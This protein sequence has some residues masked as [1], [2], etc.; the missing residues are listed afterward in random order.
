[1]NKTWESICSKAVASP[2]K[3]A[4]IH[5]DGQ[6]RTAYTWAGLQTAV[7][8][9]AA[10]LRRDELEIAALYASNSPAW[11]VTDIACE[12]AGVTL[13]PL[14]GFFST[15]QLQHALNE[16]QVDAL[17]TDQPDRL[18]QLIGQPVKAQQSIHCLTYLIVDVATSDR[19]FRSQKV[20]PPNTQKVTF[21][22]GSTGVPKGVCLSSTHL[23]QVADSIMAATDS[24]RIDTHLC[25]LPLAILLE[26][27]AGIYAPLAR[28]AQVIVATEAALGFNGA[29]G[30]NLS[31]FLA[32]LQDCQPNSLIVFPQL[33]EALVCCSEAGW[34]LPPTLRFVAVG[35]ATVGAELLNRAWQQGLPVYEGYGLSECGSVVSLNTPA[36]RKNG[37]LGKPL[38]HLHVEIIDGEI[39]VHGSKFSGYVGDPDSWRKK[40]SSGSF[41][42]GDLA[43]M[44]SEGFLHFSGRRKN[45][46][47]SSF[48][49]NI[50]P[51]W[52]ETELSAQPV[53]AQVFVFGDGQPFCVAL[54]AAQ[55]YGTSN[56][57]IEIAVK[58]VNSN[59]PEYARIKRWHR[60][61][62]PFAVGKGLATDLMTTNG[63]PRRGQIKQRFSAEIAALYRNDDIQEYTDGVLSEVKTGH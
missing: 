31:A 54:I 45:L 40:D 21:T 49:R 44:D 63:R 46:L 26:N 4:L 51:E 35:G 56:F 59:L 2:D 6:L 12:L 57:D 5:Y 58:H 60:L 47:I 24:C 19:H 39:V 11:V 52:L 7:T 18:S 1:M 36:A 14:P 29:T 32:A 61:D 16:V 30:F 3:P 8:N 53:I 22:S 17:F 41:A 55:S 25:V 37:S 10:Q 23:H 28:G 62:V 34:K 13:L 43:S 50:S 48:G 42:T 20:L 9:L 33:L 15:Q 27:V 38:P